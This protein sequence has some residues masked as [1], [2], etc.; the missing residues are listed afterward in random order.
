M[1]AKKSAKKTARKPASKSVTKRIATLQKAAPGMAQLA[2]VKRKP[3]K[4]YI[5]DPKGYVIEVP[6]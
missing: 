3:K 1:A 5:V 4:D 6:R 2:R